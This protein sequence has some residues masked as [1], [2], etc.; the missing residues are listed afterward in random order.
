MDLLVHSLS[1]SL[2]HTHT[3]VTSQRQLYLNHLTSQ[4]KFKQSLGPYLQFVH[5]TS[6]VRLGS[7]LVMYVTGVQN[8]YS[9]FGLMLTKKHCSHAHA[10]RQEGNKRYLKIP[11]ER[12]FVCQNC[13]HGVVV[14]L[15]IISWIINRQILRKKRVVDYFKILF[16]KKMWKHAKNNPHDGNSIDIWRTLL[17]NARPGALPLQITCLVC[18]PSPSPQTANSTSADAFI[19]METIA[20]T[21]KNYKIRWRWRLSLPT[22]WRHNRRSRD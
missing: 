15:L 3:H 16:E 2:T 20:D 13:K 18:G 10:F 7:Y 8:V 12:M 5:T 6:N 17:Q 11:Y 14:S 1:L 19:H 22:P 21:R 4:T 9:G